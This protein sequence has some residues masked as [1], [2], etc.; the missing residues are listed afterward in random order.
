[1]PQLVKSA[2]LIVSRSLPIYPDNRTI[3]D[4]V[5]MSQGAKGGSVDRTRL[6]RWRSHQRK[7]HRQDQRSGGLEIDD[8]LNSGRLAM[9]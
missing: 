2:V 1:M 6:P 3:S 8:Q 4:S 5:G 7:R 9:A